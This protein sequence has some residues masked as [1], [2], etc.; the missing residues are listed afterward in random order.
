MY[1]GHHIGAN[2]LKDLSGIVH[3]ARELDQINNKII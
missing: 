1:T 3:K 2:W